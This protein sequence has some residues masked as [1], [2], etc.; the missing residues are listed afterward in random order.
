[1]SRRTADPSYPAVSVRLTAVL[2]TL[3]GVIS[4]CREHSRPAPPSQLPSPTN[5]N[6]CGEASNPGR[7]DGGVVGGIEWPGGTR[8]LASPAVVY[9]CFSPFGHAI[10]SITQT[11]SAASIVPGSAPIHPG[12]GVLAVRITVTA[13]G[14]TR[15][16]LEIS[17]A[18]T[19]K[20]RLIRRGPDIVA[21]DSGWSF[22]RPKR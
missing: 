3:L 10:V 12:S 15:L 6:E 7:A 17:D 18:T 8:P 20:A 13:P 14:R 11:G 22:E 4:A 16:W 2:L 5:A 1:M 9:A 19:G 21:A